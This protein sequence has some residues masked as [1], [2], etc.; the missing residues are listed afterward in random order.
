MYI[1]LPSFDFGVLN[2]KYRRVER[3]NGYYDAKKQ[4]FFIFFYI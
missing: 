3:Q 1:Y 4:I 2:N